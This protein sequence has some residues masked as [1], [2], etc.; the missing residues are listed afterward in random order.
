MLN[1]APAPVLACCHPRHHSSLQPRRPA[2]VFATLS[3]ALL[4]LRTRHQGLGE[5][6]P[7]GE[8][9]PSSAA[10]EKAGVRVAGTWTQTNKASNLP[11]TTTN[12]EGSKPSA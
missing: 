4:W 9:I 1:S 6:R 12:A 8:G 7:G 11:V 2:A 3:A 5:R 10:F